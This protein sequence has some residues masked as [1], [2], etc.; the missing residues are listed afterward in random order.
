MVVRISYS[1]KTTRHL[2]EQ[3]RFVTICRYVSRK[4]NAHF[5]NFH[6]ALASRHPTGP[7]RMTWQRVHFIFHAALAQL[8]RAAVL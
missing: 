1:T 5:L 3:R 7:C 2:S 8:V 4:R 6:A